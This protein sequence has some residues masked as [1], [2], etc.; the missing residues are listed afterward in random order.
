MGM[1][2]L[3]VAAAFV[4]GPWTVPFAAEFTAEDIAFTAHGFVF[5]VQRQPLYLDRKRILGIQLAMT[6]AVLKS[7]AAPDAASA[8]KLLGR[9]DADAKLS[10]DQRLLI[11]N[12]VIELMLSKAPKDVKERFEWRR[13][14]L[15][16]RTPDAIG[17]KL[18]DTASQDI[19]SIL[20][21]YTS[22]PP[23]A[24]LRPVYTAYNAE[25][26]AEG[27]PIPPDWPS[28][29][30]LNRGP[31]TKFILPNLG[32]S[33]YSFTSV[34]PATPGVCLALPRWTLARTRDPAGIWYPAGTLLAL[35]V[36]CQSASTGAACF[37]DNRDRQ[38]GLLTGNLFQFS[39]RIDRI[40][41]GRTLGENCTS[42]HRGGNAFIAHPGQG[43]D[44]RTPPAL[45]TDL[46]SMRY[47]PI[48]GTE[49]SPWRNAGPLAARG[50]SGDC[51]SCHEIPEASRNYCAFILAP[52]TQRT[53]PSRTSP[54]APPPSSGDPWPLPTS[55]RYIDD[56]ILLKLA[57]S[58]AGWP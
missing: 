24:V 38:N 47:R 32:A 11:R 56:M 54:A 4:A 6:E 27:V 55:G 1:R 39:M 14:L 53:M 15:T 33:V 42:C 10:D 7:L 49:L 2:A 25:C 44:G 19:I 21:G 50:A 20:S 22:V 36:I 8:A 51:T 12:G 16:E 28:G 45:A 52:A 29:R 9:L 41:N 58:L 5:D 30:W 3:L 57:C 37:W 17:L 31:T 43:T 13:I 40:G 48:G 23:E 34:D 46:G 26:Q 35:G 18:D